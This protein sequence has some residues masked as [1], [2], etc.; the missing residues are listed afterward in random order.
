MNTLPYSPHVLGSPLSPESC[1]VR[2]II[3]TFRSKAV[4][5]S[6]LKAIPQALYPHPL[7][8]VEIV[9]VN[10]GQSPHLLELLDTLRTTALQSIKLTMLIADSVQSAAFARNAGAE[11]FQ[12]GIIIFLDDDVLCE[13]HALQL[14]IAPILEGRSDAAVGN[15][16]SDVH[17][18][19]FPQ[20]FKQLYIHHVY[21]RFQ[22]CIAE[23]WTAIGAVRADV[24]HQAHGFD[25]QHKGACG[26]DLD[27]GLR[28]TNKGHT[29]WMQ[30]D[31]RGRHLHEFTLLGI[32]R[33]DY[34][35]GII[36]V[37]E[38]LMN[39]VPFTSNRHASPKARLGVMTASAFV[40]T[41]PVMA[42]HIWLGLTLLALCGTAWA[43]SRRDLLRLY[44]HAEGVVFVLQAACLMFALDVL[45]AICIPVAVLRWRIAIYQRYSEQ[46]HRSQQMTFS[47]SPH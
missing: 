34:R 9:V 16:S 47:S 1:A 37:Y 14:L 7:S 6:C 11:N 26:E 44:H 29:I 38:S 32:I 30:N 28:I 35:K 15:Y 22:G 42:F 45:R 20:K 12:D 27:F 24:F 31:A 3:P 43:V 13:P 10:N 39:D 17:G 21:S 5:A 41:I 23:F 33:N 46:Y 4:L 2:I 18:L 25:I 8:N 36:A 19:R 40:A